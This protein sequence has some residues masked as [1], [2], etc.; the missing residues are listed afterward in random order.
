L[1]HAFLPQGAVELG[2]QKQLL[3]VSQAF[4]AEA[5]KVKSDVSFTLE[6]MLEKTVATYQELTS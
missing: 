6:S 3:E 2:N 5:P 1:L 4:L